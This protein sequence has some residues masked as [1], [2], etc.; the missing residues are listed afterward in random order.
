MGALYERQFSGEGQSIEVSLGDTGYTLVETPLAAYVEG[1]IVPQRQGN[2][3]MFCVSDAFKAKD[4]W[5]YVIA[6]A[7]GVF[8]RLCQVIG[9]PEWTEDPR[10]ASTAPRTEN[11]DVVEA[12]VAGWVAR[13]TVQEALD[14]LA[15]AQVPAA[16]MNDIP[17]AAAD[18]YWQEREMMVSVPSPK[19]GRFLVPGKIVKFSRS[20]VVVG[21][22]AA[23]GEH[24]RPIL[25]QLL[26][27]LDEDVE[28]LRAEGVI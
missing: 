17:S 7:Q 18:P 15:A 14:V 8:S 10:F 2:K 23:P 5:V 12:E 3:M 25:T 9:K 1:G 11:R 13:H 19:A 16:P 21:P 24:N 20:E 6:P 4:G 27:Y 28:R 26:G 22:I